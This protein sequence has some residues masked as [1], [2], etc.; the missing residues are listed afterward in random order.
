VLLNIILDKRLKVRVAINLKHG[1]LEEVNHRVKALVEQGRNA[2]SIFERNNCDP[3]RGVQVDA[4][5]QENDL[6]RGVEIEQGLD[7]R[8]GAYD[9]ITLA[10]V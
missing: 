10:V 6:E 5:R 8:D 7:E 1:R 2:V 9:L 4:V 3:G